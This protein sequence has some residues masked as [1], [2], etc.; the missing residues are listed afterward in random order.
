MTRI[1][2]DMMSDDDGADN[3][4]IYSKPQSEQVHR[5]SPKS[6]VREGTSLTFKHFQESKTRA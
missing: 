3:G 5:A 2:T 4:D 6:Q 1:L